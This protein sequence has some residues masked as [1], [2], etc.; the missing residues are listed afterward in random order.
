MKHLQCVKLMAGVILS[1]SALEA[2]AVVIQF[3]HNDFTMNAQYNRLRDFSFEIEVSGELTAG[4]TYTNPTLIGIEY[5]VFGI[6]DT[7]PTPSNFGAFDLQR[8]IGGSEFY[9]QGSS[10]NFAISTTADLSD[11]LQASELDNFVF[12]GR[13]V[14]TGRYHPTL[15]QIS[16]DGTGSI[17]NSNNSGGVNPGSNMVV[18]VDLA[19]E[20]LVNLTFDP[21]ALTLAEASIVP[22]PSSLLLTSLGFLGLFL[23]RR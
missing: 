1:T 9:T 7:D 11:G 23:R 4:V 15:F 14:G 20:Y 2:Q 5:S 21:A 13:E 10:F 19:D 17:Q 16:S 3:D 12:N 6:L 18:D 22:E 8:T